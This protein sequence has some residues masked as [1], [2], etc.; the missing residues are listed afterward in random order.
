MPGKIL[1]TILFFVCLEH[2]NA[3]RE[4]YFLSDCQ[5][6]ILAEK[7]YLKAYRNEEARDTL[8][9][10]IIRHK[11]YQFFL[12]GDLTSVSSNEKKWKPVDRF[13]KSLQPFH[14]Q[15]YAIPGNHEYKYLPSKGMREFEKRFPGQSIYGYCVRTDSIAIVMLN[16]NFHYIHLRK[17][18]AQ[19]KWYRQVLDSLD[20]EDGI[21][22]VV[23]CTHHA[24]FS[25]ST[26]VGSSKPVEKAFVEDFK[27]S[28]KAVLFLSGHSHN[29]ELFKDSQKDFLVI[30]GGGGLTQPLLP[31]NKRIYKDLIPQQQKPLYF[32]LILQRKGN[33]L[34][35]TARGMQR[36]FRK[37]FELKVD[38]IE[39]ERK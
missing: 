33:Q 31:E 17:S 11:P 26:I 12:L 5:Q 24:P 7:I 27:K 15:V 28:P 3:Q 37:M 21:K 35:L 10:D 6:P 9:S 8:F 2:V 1:W 4:I 19:R 13:L 20:R 30:G 16:S 34:L 38:T 22:A 36:D 23:V 32:Y 25:N 29:L 14:T 18:E 39:L